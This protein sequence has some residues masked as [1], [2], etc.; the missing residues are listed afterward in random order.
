MVPAAM[1]TVVRVTMA[2][3]VMVTT[4][5]MVRVTPVQG[6]N[7]QHVLLIAAIRYSC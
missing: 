2:T 7:Q 3:A 5:T 6:N 1:V 4:V